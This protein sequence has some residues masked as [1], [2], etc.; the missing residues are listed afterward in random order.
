MMTVR[1]RSEHK[2]MRALIHPN[3]NYVNGKKA[4]LNDH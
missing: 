1:I 2:I 3:L 4:G